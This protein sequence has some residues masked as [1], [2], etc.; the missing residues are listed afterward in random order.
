MRMILEN[1]NLAGFSVDGGRRRE[2]D[3][4][5]AVEGEEI[6]QG[7]R[8]GDVL[9]EV[10]VRLLDRLTDGDESCEVHAGVDPMILHDAC[11]RSAVS[12]IYP[13]E[14]DITAQAAVGTPAQIVNDDHRLALFNHVVDDSST[15]IPGSAGDENAHSDRSPSRTLPDASAN[16]P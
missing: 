8:L 5:D 6:E 15:D 13:V 1:R 14:G 16:E 2:H 10:E 4:A 11:D 9:L 7:D 12:D 3:I